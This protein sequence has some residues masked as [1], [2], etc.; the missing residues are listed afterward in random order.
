LIRFISCV[1]NLVVFVSVLFNTSSAFADSSPVLAL[2]DEV[3]SYMS[4][5][6]T[7]EELE[8]V[9]ST[10]SAL[11]ISHVAEDM[12]VVTAADITRMNA[13]T[14]E[15]VLNT[16]TGMQVFLSG[17]PGTTSMS[18]IQGSDM[19]HVT[20]MI[21]GVVLNTLGDNVS[22]NAMIPV[23]MIQKIEIIKGPASSV[24]GSSLGGIVN[25]ITKTGGLLS[26]GN[27]VYT[28]LGKNN[29]DDFRMETMGKTDRLGYYLTAG[30]LQSDGL[31]PHFGLS[32]NNAYGKLTYGLT[33][34]T[35]ILFTLGYVHVK[36][37][38][39]EDDLNDQFYK[40]GT[41]LAH[42]TLAVNTALN[43]DLSL[44][45]ALRTM[46]N[47]AIYQTYQL[48]TGDMSDY[49]RYTDTGYGSSAKLTWKNLFNTVVAGVDYDDKT[50]K[51]STFSQNE[52]TLRT[53]SL[54][55]NDTVLL[56]D[57]SITPGIRQD[58]TNSNG[59]VTSPSLGVAYGIIQNT[60]LRI[61]AGNGFNIPALGYTYGTSST[62]IGN[63][64][65][66]PEKVRS[67][68]GG[69]ETALHYLWIKAS[70]FR[71]DIQD[72]MFQQQDFTT[73]VTQY[74]NQIKQRRQ[75]LDIAM[76]TAPIYN[77]SLI[78]GAEF[79]TAKDLATGQTLYS[80]PTRVY[81]LGIQYDDKSSVHALLKGRYIDWNA[82]PATAGTAWAVK[83]RTF[84]FDLN[85]IKK[86]YQNKDT[87]LEIFLTGHNIFNQDQ[88]LYQY[89]SN[90]KQWFEGGLKC[91]F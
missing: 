12:A 46:N 32:N 58:K 42:S 34:K 40:S 41:E 31:T 89:Y 50:L 7:P 79:V 74:V 68:Q 47:R 1:L 65:L 63:P 87:S 25:V 5:Y 61:Y 60:V 14:L 20:V 24:W 26:Q 38:T 75:G 6:F 73:G 18:Y 45:I 86:V 69:V 57:L 70:A 81:D 9:S 62:S 83:D 54:F 35:D 56:G 29:T 59:D 3:K 84:V 27:M 11:P 21:D 48:S 16:V 76:K 72:A 30:R 67:Y 15:E 51:A 4:M 64:D 28:S 78:A 33:D 23:Q 19:R 43:T 2:S 85:M 44:N 8:V 82:D 91:T 55:I 10:R 52:L 53:T 39:G 71:N 22:E 90:P 80:T 66:K 17:G 36:R 49:Q 77:T 13:H 88:Y 37:D